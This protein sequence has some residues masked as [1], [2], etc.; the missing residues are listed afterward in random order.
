MDPFAARR[1]VSTEPDQLQAA[2]VGLMIDVRANYLQKGAGPVPLVIDLDSLVRL[3]GPNAI[4]VLEGAVASWFVKKVGE[5]IWTRIVAWVREVQK[6][7]PDG[8]SVQAIAVDNAKQRRNYKIPSDERLEA[9]ITQ[10]PLDLDTAGAPGERLWV[11]GRW[12]TSAEYWNRE[13]RR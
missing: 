9:A 7:S 4:N 13:N 12:M 6:R 5:S 2:A 10:L 3:Y 1:K 11:D 8:A